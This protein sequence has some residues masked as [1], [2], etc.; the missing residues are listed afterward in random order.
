MNKTKMVFP[1]D[2]LSTL[3]ELNPGDGTFEEDGVIRASRVGR[4]TID[5]K[6]REARVTPLTDIPIE[7]KKGDIV[8]A[9]VRSTRSSMVIAD[10]IH[11]KGKNRE[12]SG[13]TNGTLMVSEISNRYIKKANTEFAAGDILRA[14]VIQVNPSIQLSTKDKDLGVIKGRCKE[15]RN[16]L[17]KQG[18]KLKCPNCG[19]TERR[20]TASDYGKYDVKKL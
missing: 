19:S 18:K 2:Q 20:T 10:V 9:E 13:D 6:D 14:K 4:F 17:V 5:K 7:V 3:E 1:G 15:C 8:L 11:V 16:P 12:I